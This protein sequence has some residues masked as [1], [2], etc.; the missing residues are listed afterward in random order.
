MVDHI[1]LWDNS[2][3]QWPLQSTTIE[4][5]AKKMYFFTNTCPYVWFNLEIIFTDSKDMYL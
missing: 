2:Y 5:L 1:V 4:V 3:E